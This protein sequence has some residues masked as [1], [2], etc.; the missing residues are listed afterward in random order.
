MLSAKGSD[1]CFTEITSLSIH[2]TVTE[3]STHLSRGEANS[4]PACTSV[5]LHFYCFGF[6]PFLSLLPKLSHRSEKQAGYFDRTRQSTNSH[7]NPLGGKALFWEKGQ[8]IAG[9]KPAQL[10]PCQGVTP[11]P[12]LQPQVCPVPLGSVE[13][14]RAQSHSTGWHC[15]QGSSEAV[16]LRKHWLGIL[17]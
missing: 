3:T 17:Q 16:P 8:V 13:Q 9:T 6:T 11:A 14:C 5:K 15:Q 12:G 7:F 1:R 10:P 2:C 4:Q